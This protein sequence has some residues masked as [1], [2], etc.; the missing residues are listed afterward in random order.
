MKIVSAKLNIEPFHSLNKKDIK[1]ILSLVPEEWKMAIDQV[2]LSSE[3]FENSRF[4]RPVIHSSISRRLN[5]LSRGLTKRRM[6]KE[7]LRELALNG[8]VAQSGFANHVCK[9]E[10]AKLD[11]TVEPLVLAFFEDE[12]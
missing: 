4:D 9:A 11:E 5:V 2:V 12:I 3:L 7:V 10:L 8:G 1:R 6:V